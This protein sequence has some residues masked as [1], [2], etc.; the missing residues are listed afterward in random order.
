MERDRALRIVTALA[1]ALGVARLAAAGPST[2]GA[3]PAPDL[4]SAARIDE[5]ALDAACRTPNPFL[6]LAVQ[7]RL[8]PGADASGVP[9][10]LAFRHAAE[11]A[12]APVMLASRAD[13]GDVYGLAFDHVRSHLYAAAYHRAG[14]AYGPG[15][16][17]AIYR[18]DIRDGRI[19][20]LQRLDAGPDLHAAGDAARSAAMVGKTSLGDID[21]AEN[22]SEL[23]VADL[24]AGEVV[25]LS[26]PDGRVRDRVSHGG[27]RAG[28]ARLF[29]L[30]VR[31]G[32]VYH[33]VVDT[34][35]PAGSGGALRASVLRALPGARDAHR[36]LDFRLDY[37]RTFR[38]VPWRPWRDDSTGP[39]YDSAMAVDVAFRPDGAPIVGLRDRVADMAPLS[40]WDP[41][42]RA[43]P[44]V[45]DIVPSRL[46]V[47]GLAWEAIRQPPWYQDSDPDD[48]EVTFGALAALPDQDVLASAGRVREV[49]TTAAH[50]RLAAYWFSNH[51]GSVLR[52]QVV[53][54]AGAGAGSAPAPVDG[55]APGDVE[56]LCPPRVEIPEDLRATGTAEARAAA[57]ARASEA[58][59]IRATEHAA[60]QTAVVPVQEARRTAAA[61]TMVA[62]APEL[63]EQA[64]TQI[65]AATLAAGTAEAVAPT[66]AAHGPTAAALATRRAAA[67]P[68]PQ[69][70]VTA[71][72]AAYD[73]IKD[74]CGT[75]NPFLVTTRFVPRLDGNGDAY[76]P[77]WLLEQPAVVAFHDTHPQ[78]RSQHVTL[79]MEPQVGA[80]Y[81]V[82]HDRERDHVY[83]GAYVKRL[84]GLGP[85]GPGGVYRIDLRTGAV[86]PFAVLDAGT[87]PHRM[88]T[89]FD[90]PA[91]SAVG[92]VGLG[93][94]EMAESN[95]QVFVA[96]LHD[97]LIYR[98]SVP[99]GRLLGAFPH[100][101]AGQWWAQDAVPFGLAV[102]DG[103]LY[104]GVVDSAMARPPDGPGGARPPAAYVYRSRADGSQ[105][106]EVVRLDFDYGRAPAWQSW[107]AV[108]P[109]GSRR[110]EPML[111]DIEFRL[112]GDLILGIR[113]RAGD[114]RIL[115]AGHG[116]MVLTMRVESGGVGERFI[117]L[118]IPEV[119]Q[120]NL[121]H[122]ES[123]WGALAALPWLDET[124][125]TVID[126][127]NIYSGGAAWFDN[128]GGGVTRLEEVYSGANQTFGKASGLGDIE[129]L[130][131]ALTP[132]PSP[133]PSATATTLLTE[134]STA[135]PTSTPTATR[136]ATPRTYTIFLPMAQ[137]EPKCVPQAVHSDVILVLDM[138]TSMYR[139]TEAD[140]TKHE[141]AL[142]A[143][144]RFAALMAL[145]PDEHGGHDQLA[146]VGFNDTAW[147]EQR[148]TNDRAV[149]DAALEGLLPR[150]AEGTRLDLA[151]QEAVRV[152]GGSEWRGANEPVMILLTDGLPNRVP[153]PVPSGSQEETVEQAA[154]AA[155]AAGLRVFTVGLGE[156]DD[157]LRPL[158]ERCAS[159]RSMYYYAP[160]GEDLVAIYRAIAG[161]IIACP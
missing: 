29:G 58:A 152:A 79:A 47:D 93:D 23:Y 75:H 114:A 136:T 1:C 135:P 57:T 13:V 82:A 99:D 2:D 21:I 68:L 113:D 102:R 149:L 6:A 156:P 91:A 25:R 141:A 98:Y 100:G 87:D 95:D 104:H 92:R 105:L 64:P 147:T 153:T 34:R 41:S 86:H 35:V 112:D 39:G 46:D 138:S 154:A 80:V 8:P 74:T 50:N 54:D 146:V 101:A 42:D 103:W 61:G 40:V 89:D 60:T 144:R 160:D 10:V 19:D 155:K 122:S 12:A 120:D 43:G 67:T 48:I 117:P 142:D 118:T 22:G 65:A 4:P 158:L 131:A 81:G 115:T 26:L 24:H 116:D 66:L 88:R 63:T 125:S 7:G 28:D 27:D 53:W 37:A 20:E 139:R 133:T 59:V 30:G 56:V 18:I 83:V 124:V 127:I 70:T 44:S 143:A 84:A 90:L 76:G 71:A 151:F 11:G 140:R 161:R 73:R 9:A 159:D 3:A 31:G 96:N 109:D 137:R 55:L 106:S 123:S 145:E 108:V 16:P 14:G 78:D 134:T 69:A 107:Q 36:V 129:V 94:I 52:W 128:V 5:G 130:C 62:L 148:L 110:P 49:V 111:A 77:W 85:L 17:G 119:Y 32:W 121:R 150:I 72:A 126:P 33:A 97:K 132:T 38:S 157:V 51:S 45:G 15:G